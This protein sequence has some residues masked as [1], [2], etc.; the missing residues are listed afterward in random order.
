MIKKVIEGVNLLRAFSAF[1]IAGAIAG[2]LLANSNQ[3]LYQDILHWM[4]VE[5]LQVLGHEFTL[6]FLV[7]ELFMALFFGIAAKEIT[8]SFL[9]NG[10]L[11]SPRK[12]MNPLIATI[13]GVLGPITVFF[14]LTALV[15]HFA[16]IPGADWDMLSHAWGVPTATDIALAWL[17]AALVFGKEH[18]AVKFLLLL[19]VVDDGIGLAIIAIFY[20][21]PLNPAQPEWL[22]LVTLA[23]LVAFG[24]RLAKVQSWVPYVLVSGTISWIGLTKAHLHPALALVFVVP[25]MPGPK[26]DKGLFLEEGGTPS[27]EPKS[28]LQVFEHRFKAIVDIGLFAFA[29]ANAGVE[30]KSIGPMT[31]VVFFSLLIGKT[32]GIYLFSRIASRMG[33]PLPEGMTRRHLFLTGVIAAIGFTVALFVAGVAFPDVTLQGQGK[34]GAV[35]SGAIGFLALVLGQLLRVQRITSKPPPKKH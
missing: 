23:M 13:G 26:S 11:S 8:E 17:F 16:L 31:W 10:S 6:H 19:A 5:G 27:H 3:S 29:F 24:L 25:F 34:M 32:G 20:G 9:P 30:V 2:M 7:N 4:P 15:C 1:L 21:N 28:T 14:C 12:A 18:P 33:F 22:L 35:F